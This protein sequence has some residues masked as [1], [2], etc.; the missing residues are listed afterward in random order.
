M[1]PQVPFFFK[2]FSVHFFHFNILSSW[3]PCLEWTYFCCPMSWLHW[4]DHLDFFIICCH[5]NWAVPGLVMP[6][7]WLPRVFFSSKILKYVSSTYPKDPL[8]PKFLLYFPV[9]LFSGNILSSLIP[10]YVVSRLITYMTQMIIAVLLRC[11]TRSTLWNFAS[12]EFQ[13]QILT[14][15]YPVFISG[16][17]WMIM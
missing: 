10:D 12:F 7:A 9:Q 1:T 17:N 11:K 2:Y 16:G 4:D 6:C 13:K 3:T 15:N 14:F 5:Q 8:K